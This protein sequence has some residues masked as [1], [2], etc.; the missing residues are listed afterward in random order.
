MLI[1]HELENNIGLT[2]VGIKSLVTLLVIILQQDSRILTHGHLQ[3]L[4][5]T[6][7]T[8]GIGLRTLHGAPT[9]HRIG[10][11]RDEQIRLVTIGDLRP[12]IQLD[13]AI[14]LTRVNDL[15]PL[16]T[17]LNEAA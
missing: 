3:V 13:E 17:P 10:M 8:Q 12:L 7:Q 6:R 16:A 9:L 15:H 4:V 5:R 14:C 11:D 1:L 2:G